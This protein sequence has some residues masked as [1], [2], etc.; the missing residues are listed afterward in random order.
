M[1]YEYSP[2]IN[3]PVE[4]FCDMA[5]RDSNSCYYQHAEEESDDSDSS[6][7]FLSQ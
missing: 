4:G 1:E 2:C 6:D 5:D 7:Y 3:C